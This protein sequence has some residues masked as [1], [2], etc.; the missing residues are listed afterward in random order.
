MK[1]V[2][3]KILEQFAPLTMRVIQGITLI[4]AH[5]NKMYMTFKTLKK[6]F[7]FSLV[8]LSL[9]A[10]LVGQNLSKPT[11]FRGKLSLVLE[12][13]YGI[14]NWDFY[15]YDNYVLEK[16]ITII[17]FTN[18]TIDKQ[19]RMTTE[20][21]RQDNV[22]TDYI[23]TDFNTKNCFEF[24]ASESFPEVCTVFA[25]KD[26][27]KG[28]K[29]NDEPD[30][31]IK[32]NDLTLFAFDKDTIIAGKKYKLLKSHDA[33]DVGQGLKSN[34]TFYLDPELKIPF[35]PFSKYLDEKFQGGIV[36]R[37]DLYT[38][39]KTSFKCEF[40]EGK[41]ELD[42]IQKYISLAKQYEEVK[43]IKAKLSD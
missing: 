5:T 29:F 17:N 7:L 15:I 43:K 11:S 4:K 14:P 12:P 28:Q 13:D 18:A 33:I 41:E 36:R 31:N 34:I 6:I 30:F 23:L 32:Y 27:V 24:D 35:H 42:F 16:V 37:E 19:G 22:L 10:A 9:S 3:I 8:F 40:K 25:L 2:S 26:K 21:V 20:S 39:G 38:E 1:Y